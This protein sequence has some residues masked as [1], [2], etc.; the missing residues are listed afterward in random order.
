MFVLWVHPSSVLVKDGIQHAMVAIFEGA[1]RLFATNELD[2][3]YTD[4]RG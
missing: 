4:P 3:Y 2:P 1:R